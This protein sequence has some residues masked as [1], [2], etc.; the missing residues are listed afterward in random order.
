M[1]SE[2]KDQKSIVLL[3]GG[4]DSAVTLYVAL[5]RSCEVEALSFDYGQRA[6][7]EL[8]SAKHLAEKAGVIW[9]FIDMPLNTSGSVLTDMK[10]KMPSGDASIGGKIPPTYV[11]ARNLVFLA[12][13]INWAES[14]GADKL[15]IGAHQLDYS[16][17]PDCREA[18]FSDFRKAVASGTR[19]GV[20][21]SPVEI[22]TPV[23]NMN[24][25]NII[26]MGDE[27]N[28]PFE[29]TWSCYASGDK[30]CRECESCILREKAFS[31][32]GLED[33]LLV[34]R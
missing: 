18:F 3:S 21:G 12:F 22:V 23:I 34:E 9:H 28:V 7:K 27:L 5:G 13:G 15:Y 25:K 2:K 8:Q 6:Q 14:T 29:H 20:E 19:S 4:M 24:K 1:I 26:M 17:Y 33:P 10:R 11:P 31:E 30:P 16:N 32:A